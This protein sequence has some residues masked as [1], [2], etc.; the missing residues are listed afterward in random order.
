MIHGVSFLRALL[1]ASQT[2]CSLMGLK[3]QMPLSRR[4]FFRHPLHY[5]HI[6]PEML[7]DFLSNVLPALCFFPLYLHK[8]LAV[9][10]IYAILN[11]NVILR[12]MYHDQ[13]FINYILCRNLPVQ[14]FYG[15]NQMLF[16]CIMYTTLF[17][18]IFYDLMVW[19]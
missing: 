12:K 4:L 14:T 8:K 6:Y 9:F 16:T 3:K 5:N 17:Y 19:N 15:C 18:L 13:T 10:H 11:L 7:L 1:S 2:G